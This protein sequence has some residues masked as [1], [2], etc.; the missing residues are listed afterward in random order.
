M[1]LKPVPFQK[2]KAG[3]KT[4]ELRL[5]DEKRRQLS[6][7]DVIVFTE[8][9]SG[10]TLSVEIVALHSFDSFE[11]LYQSLDLE[12]CGYLKGELAAASPADM[13]IYYSREEQL[14]CGVLGIEIILH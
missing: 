11:T 4:I 5:N 12:K 8:A 13:D 3:E 1:Q 10:E 14:R 9:E 7:G 2:I 6:I